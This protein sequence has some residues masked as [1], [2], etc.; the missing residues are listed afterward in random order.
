MI[1]VVEVQAV[2]LLVFCLLGSKGKEI[3]Y[4]FVLRGK[5]CKNISDKKDDLVTERN[6][7]SFFKGK[8]VF[9][10]KIETRKMY[11]IIK[12]SGKSFLLK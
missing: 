5:K 3:L 10:K 6:F 8:K 7:Y 9:M 12:E 11:V 1:F 4:I 2:G